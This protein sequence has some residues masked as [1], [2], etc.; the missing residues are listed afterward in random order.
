VSAPHADTENELEQAFISTPDVASGM[1]VVI[2]GRNEGERLKLCLRSLRGLSDRTVY[3]DSGSSDGSVALAR[4]AGVSVLELD[5]NAPFTAARARN[6]GLRSLLELHPALEYVFFV[7]GDTEIAP[8]WPETA[9]RFLRDHPDIA[10][11]WGRVRERHPDKSVYNMLFDIDWQDVPLGQ[12]KACGGTSVMRVAA[13]K[14][15]QGYRQDLIAGEDP[16]LCVRLR[17]AGWRIWGL[18]ESMAV[19]DAALHDFRQ[20]WRRSV[21]TGYAFAIGAFLHGAPPERNSVLESRRAWI[22][23]LWI[24]VA[25][26]VMAIVWGW[27]ALALAA[28]YPLQVARLALGGTRSARENWWRGAALVLSKFPEMLGQA[29]FMLDRHRRGKSGLIEYK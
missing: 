8:E 4:A 19:H 3:V 18:S 15:V 27:W 13:F 11:A 14:E 2:I 9:V 12:S 23:G 20:S 21:R 10:A 26:V 28:L 22:W 25:I 7:D 1:G 29:K 5:A 16:D 17:Q 24:P 6:E